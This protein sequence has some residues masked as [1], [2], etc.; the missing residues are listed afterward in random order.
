MTQL[1]SSTPSL[2]SPTAIV[3]SSC[4]CSATILPSGLRQMVVTLRPPQVVRPPRRVRRQLRARPRVLQ[5]AR[6]RPKLRVLLKHRGRMGPS[7]LAWPWLSS[8]LYRA[9]WFTEWWDVSTRS[10]KLSSILHIVF[11]M[12]RAKG[13]EQEGCLVSSIG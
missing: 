9:E 6:L 12:L 11:V 10:S 7:A 8:S 5:P 2:K 1:R 3:L 13:R 4:S